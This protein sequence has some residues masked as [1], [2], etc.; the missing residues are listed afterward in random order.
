MIA[1]L[2]VVNKSSMDHPPNRENATLSK[3]LSIFPFTLAIAPSH[4][5]ETSSKK[6]KSDNSLIKDLV[7]IQI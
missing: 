6:I 1:Q 7:D 2:E 4:P 3:Q 5:K